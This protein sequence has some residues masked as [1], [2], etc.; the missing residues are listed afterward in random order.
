MMRRFGVAYRTG[1]ASIDQVLEAIHNSTLQVPNEL[2]MGGEQYDSWLVFMIELVEKLPEEHP[3]RLACGGLYTYGQHWNYHSTWD[4][5]KCA[6]HYTTLTTRL[7]PVLDR[8]ASNG[9]V[10]R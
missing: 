4:E 9:S 1:D 5:K 8:F 6:T 3:V 2:Q 10:G 7:W